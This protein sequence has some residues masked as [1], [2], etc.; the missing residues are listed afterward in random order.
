MSAGLAPPIRPDPFMVGPHP[1]RDLGCWRRDPLY[2]PIAPR[3]KPRKRGHRRA[4]IQLTLEEDQAITSLLKL[5]YQDPATFTQKDL[6]EGGA[7]PVDHM[8]TDHHLP[9]NQL[10]VGQSG[11]SPIEQIGPYRR[12]QRSSAELEAANALLTL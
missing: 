1:I 5:H 12:G 7:S 3:P 4:V 9:L 2:Q 8:A 11:P 6:S 10:Q